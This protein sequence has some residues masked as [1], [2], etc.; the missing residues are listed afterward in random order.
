MQTICAAPLGA[1]P[2]EDA[3]RL[4]GQLKRHEGLR[5]AAY[6]DGVGVLTIGYGHNCQAW[7]LPGVLRPGDTISREQAL[8]LFRED[9]ELAVAQT[10]HA[11]PWMSS[12]CPPRQAV[13][14][15]MSFNLG[16]G[17]AASGR[18]LL[19]FR[20]LLAAVR[21]GDYSL[22][23]GEMLNSRW[24]GQVG[25][26]AVELAVQMESGRWAPQAGGRHA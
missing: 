6:L 9:L 11:L 26:R 22:A 12:L 13:L 8:C 18:G 2:P 14:I 1:M 23:A 7:P 3:E 10:A 16:L 20:R 24:A 15:N 25:Q 21:S 4:A 5:L 17:S 19:G